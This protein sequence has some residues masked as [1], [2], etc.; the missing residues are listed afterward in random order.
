MK[1]INKDKLKSHTLSL[2]GM[3]FVVIPIIYFILI[4]AYNIWINE[5]ELLYLY[6]D[7]YILCIIS[8]FI[9]LFLINKSMKEK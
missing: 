6:H 4:R 2:I 1:K 7:K 8:I 5:T 3:I 9:G